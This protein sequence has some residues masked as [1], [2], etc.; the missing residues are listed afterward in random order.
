MKDAPDAI[1]AEAA[2]KCKPLIDHYSAILLLDDHPDV[3]KAVGADGVHLGKSDMH[4]SQAR[5]ILGPN[6]I[7]G[8]TA[9]TLEDIHAICSHGYSDYIGLGPLRFT[10]TKK[11]L[12]PTLGYDGYERILSQGV[13]L[14]VVGI[15]AVGID[16]V[17]PLL[18][19]GVSGVAVSGSV[20]NAPSPVT[21]ATKLTA[22]L[23]ASALSRVQED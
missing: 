8:S 10:S 3:A 23:S 22:A 21:A 20:R 18:A 16:D 17:A 2:H 5:A 1:V 7:I 13:E 14:P 11:N 4:P 6:A 19:R 15:G 9:N 12:S